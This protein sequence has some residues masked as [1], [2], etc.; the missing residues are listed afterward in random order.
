[1]AASTPALAQ[2]KVVIGYQA[3]PEWA[4]TKEVME[5][6]E[7]ATG[8]RIPIDNKNS[9]QAL[10]QLMAERANPQADIGFNHGITFAM[11]GAAEG[12]YA[13]YKPKQWSDIPADLKDPNGLWFTIYTGTIGFAVNKEALG[14][15]VPVPRSWND[16]LKPIY[17]GKIGLLD[18]SSAFVGY[19]VCTAVNLAQGGTLDNWEPGIAYL[20]K[21]FE[22][23]PMTPKQTSYARV[24]KGEIPI[25]IDYDFNAYRMKYD[26]KV[27][28]EWVIPTEGTIT[29]PYVAYLVKGAPRLDNGKKLLDFLLDD[30]GQAAFARGFVRPI[31]PGAMDAQTRA[32]FLPASEYARARAVDYKK[33]ADVMTDFQARYLKEVV[34]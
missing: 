7:Q 34:R 27:D 28:V 12:L 14:A 1:V 10:S 9:G 19:V 17:K 18:P 21:L 11:K 20:K 13:P 25:M 33:M 26:D 6:F 5:K 3:A 23:S 15:N 32:K 24:V 4:N 31:R 29:V 2:Q 22:N 8:I 30:A 16:L